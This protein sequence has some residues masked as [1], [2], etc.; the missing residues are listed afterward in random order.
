[1]KPKMD[2]H[3]DVREWNGCKLA[4]LEPV[5]S[6]CVDGNGLFGTDIRT[7][8]EVT[9]LALLLSLQIQTYQDNQQTN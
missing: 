5:D 1:M 7:V 9:V 3:V 8:L 2:I 4:A 6:R